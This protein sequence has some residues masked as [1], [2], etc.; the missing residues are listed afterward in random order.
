MESEGGGSREIL[1]AMEADLK[2]AQQRPAWHQLE[3]VNKA[4][5]IIVLVVGIVIAAA[6]GGFD[7]GAF[8]FGG[9]REAP[10]E[11]GRRR[12]SVVGRLSAGYSRFRATITA[13]S[14]S[15]QA[16]I[17]SNPASANQVS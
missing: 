10:E 7:F 17:A 8:D 3:P 16:A 6:D 14:P 1:A 5:L 9:D 12:R 2:Q 4:R 11:T 13:R 15:C